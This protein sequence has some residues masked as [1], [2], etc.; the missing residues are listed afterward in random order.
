MGNRTSTV[1][2][3][4]T[5]PETSPENLPGL[6]S[7]PT[8]TPKTTSASAA[9]DIP[10]APTHIPGLSA[11]SR[12]GTPT[13]A[14]LPAAGDDLLITRRLGRGAFARVYAVEH[15]GEER[16]AK[17]YR[18]VSRLRQCARS[19][20]DALREVESS[21]LFLLCHATYM[22]RDHM[23]LV[24]E[25]AVCDLYA[26]RKV[27]L[28]GHGV[29]DSVKVVG[30]TLFEGLSHLHACGILHTDIKPENIL[31]VRRGGT[32]HLVISDL[33]SVMHGA[34]RHT[35]HGDI[36]SSWYRAPELYLTG[37]F[38]VPIDVWS[39]A[40]VVYE[41]ATGTPLFRHPTT[42][43][44]SLETVLTELFNAHETVL[45]ACPYGNYDDSGPAPW[46][47]TRIARAE[48]KRQVVPRVAHAGVA[49]M[50]G[51]IC[52]WDAAQRPTAGEM[53]TEVDLWSDA[54]PAWGTPIGTRRRTEPQPVAASYP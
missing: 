12:K 50:L 20:R 44:D 46:L 17:I 52:I 18:A 39:A 47:A 5:L 25:L 45:G 37:W 10:F 38:G 16:A 22:C 3:R 36:T 14:S 53:A 41:H 49:L 11:S 23:I 1:R 19:E 6:P 7:P 24:L 13:F 27:V 54:A 29:A 9:I 30:K 2:Y 28:Q 34:R 33:G 31:R 43:S 32:I 4:Q 35:T 42:H 51:K 48:R 21:G 15:E 26:H 8:G 40:C